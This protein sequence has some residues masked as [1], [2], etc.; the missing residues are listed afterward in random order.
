MINDIHSCQTLNEKC[1]YA[2]VLVFIKRLASKTSWDY[3]VEIKKDG[4]ESEALTEHASY[5]E[6]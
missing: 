4:C 1:I 6:V 5:T 3:A 2:P